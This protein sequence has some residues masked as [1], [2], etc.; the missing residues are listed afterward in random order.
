MLIRKFIFNNPRADDIMMFD[1][2]D[3]ADKCLCR[4]WRFPL[5]PAINS[6]RS[7]LRTP[8]VP[9][10][11]N[12]LPFTSIWIY[13]HPTAWCF[14]LFLL[15]VLWMIFKWA[16]WDICLVA[17]LAASRWTNL[18][19]HSSCVPRMS[20]VVVAPANQPVFDPLSP[21]GG[22]CVSTMC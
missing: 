14:L 5:R 20:V 16:F 8:A 1:F 19:P 15:P 7:S 11:V 2:K 18:C 3:C 4:S 21:G 6:L 17:A 12:W 9:Y 22:V 10:A 13:S